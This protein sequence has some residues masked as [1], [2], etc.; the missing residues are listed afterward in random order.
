[1]LF[2]QLVAAGV[3]EKISSLEAKGTAATATSLL[4][5]ILLFTAS[6]SSVLEVT[7]SKLFS[8]L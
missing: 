5:V 2:A 6:L 3:R 1:V 8:I 7:P 4:A